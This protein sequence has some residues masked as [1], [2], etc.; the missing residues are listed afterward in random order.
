MTHNKQL[1]EAAEAAEAI[2]PSPWLLRPDKH[3][4]WGVIRQGVETED[5][6]RWV[7]AQVR[8]SKDDTFDQNVMAEHRRNGTDPHQEVA[9]FIAAANPSTVLG[10]LDEID[11]LNR[12]VKMSGKASMALAKSTVE[13]VDEA[14][15]LKAQ[16]ATLTA[17]RDAMRE[18]LNPFGRLAD[19]II[20]TLPDH[21]EDHDAYIG[22]ERAKAQAVI[23]YGDLRR[24]AKAGGTE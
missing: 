10:L 9:D 2:A 12:M 24:A 7:V 6:F 4:D 19:A 11:H 14:S 8:A 5:G 21:Y 23:T 20:P 17:E 16:I 22:V 1:R 3:D 13:G 15:E 18:A